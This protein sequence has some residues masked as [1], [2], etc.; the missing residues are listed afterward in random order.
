[1]QIFKTQDHLRID[2][3]QDIRKVEVICERETDFES[4]FDFAPV[5]KSILLPP[6]VTES[7]S[8][9]SNYVLKYSS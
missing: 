7:A 2:L 4:D 1:M 3:L 6:P 5:K 8:Y 9:I